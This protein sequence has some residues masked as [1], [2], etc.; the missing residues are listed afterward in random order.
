MSYLN[1]EVT[2]SEVEWLNENYTP[3]IKKKNGIFSYATVIGTSSTMKPY[4]EEEVGRD[5]DFLAVPNKDV[6]L[7]K[8]IQ[9]IYSMVREVNKELKERQNKI[10]VPFPDSCIQ[11]LITEEGADFNA[12]SFL[13]GDKSIDELEE[14]KKELYRYLVPQHIILVDSKHGIQR[15]LPDNFPVQ[16]GRTLAG[17]Y[18]LIPEERP[19][20]DTLVSL[21]FEGFH[22]HSGTLMAPE[23]HSGNLVRGA[24]VHAIEQTEKGLSKLLSSKEDKELLISK[25][26]KEVLGE[27][28]NSKE[29]IE[30]ASRLW[31]KALNEFDEFVTRGKGKTAF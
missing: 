8:F 1:S 3:K 15:N 5:Y 26:K 20:D 23:N 9:E 4:S 6:T 17:S 11:N 18:E 21:Y 28:K 2:A 25:D 12:K 14:A 13:G 7:G 24:T 30:V 16:E 19:E 27:E 29:N 10:G 22:K 31:R